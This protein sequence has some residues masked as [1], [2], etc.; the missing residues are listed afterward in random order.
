MKSFQGAL[1]VDKGYLRLEGFHPQKQVAGVRQ[2]L[3]DELKRL[4]AVPGGKGL[5]GS[6]Q[7]LPLFQQIG[8]LSALVKA[9]GLHEALVTPG[10]IDCVTR[11]GGRAPSAI[12]D[13]QLLLSPP[14]QGAS[15][16]E[17]LNWHVDIAA[18]PQDPLPGVQAFFLIDDVAPG[19][20]ATLA[21][22][23]SHRAGAPGQPS[24]ARLRE[25]LKT[26]GDLARNLEQL[27]IGIVEM[28][29]RAGDVFL[30][31]L[32]LLHTPSVNSTK[33]VRMMATAR[34]FFSRNT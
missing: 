19:G 10:L 13:T 16:L 22:A 6:L 31:D 2:K 17:G 15:T 34:C 24:A 3:L 18:R 5:P 12:Q 30:M 26:P 9:P 32:R 7:R 1:F 14:S 27:G 33:N 11:L 4:K 28:S 8:K 21:L 20:G 29:G 23:G 25:A